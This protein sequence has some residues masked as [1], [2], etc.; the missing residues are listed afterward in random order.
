MDY[1]FAPPTKHAA[2]VHALLAANR[3]ETRPR[4]PEFNRALRAEIRDPT[5]L[6]A[7]QWQL[8][9]FRAEDRGTPAFAEVVVSELVAARRD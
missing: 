1:S 4:S 8:H 2:G 9:E 6:L 5:W 7:R 3:L